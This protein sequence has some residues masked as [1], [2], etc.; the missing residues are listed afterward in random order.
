MDDES[1]PASSDDFTAFLQLSLK[2]F[3]ALKALGN[4]NFNQ[5]PPLTN[6]YTACNNPQVPSC[7]YPDI[8]AP[9][10]AESTS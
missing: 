10:Y 6:T 2:E 4:E 5:A 9:F 8:T 3:K 1:T 7:V